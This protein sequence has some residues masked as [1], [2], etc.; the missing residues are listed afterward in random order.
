MSLRLLAFALPVLIAGQPALAA[1]RSFTV[2]GF[3]RIRLDGPYSV[4]L[5]TGVAPFAR[6]KGSS[7]ALN[8]LS[9]EVQGQTLIIRPSRSSWGGY[10]GKDPGPVEISIGTHD[11]T[12]VWLNGAG[13]LAIDS[14][15]GQSFDMTVQGPGSI[16]LGKLDVDRLNLGLAGSGSAVVGGKTKNATIIVRGSASLDGSGL[17]AKDAI[18]GAEGSAVVRL[19][20]TGTVKIDALG[21]AS[22]AIAGDPACK[23]RT[24]GSATVSGCR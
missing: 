24:V 6:A 17:T 1:E 20:V 9:V 4:K 12:K 8:G 2:V 15:E 21:T 11:L 3:E 14:V 5:T 18:V 13:A 7:A 23:L 10:P 22:I 19:G 16:A